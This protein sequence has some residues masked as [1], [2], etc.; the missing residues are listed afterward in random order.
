MFNLLSILQQLGHKVTFVPANLAYEQPYVGLLQERGI[1]VIHAPYAKSVESYIVKHARHFDVI[2]LSRANVADR[3]IGWINKYAPDAL[4]I[5][6]TVDLHF[7]REQR[8]AEVFQSAS[9]RRLA[10]KRKRQ[11][12]AI[13]SRADITLVVSPVEKSILEEMAP[14]LSVEIVSTIHETQGGATSFEQREGILFIGGFHHPPNVDAVVYYVQ[15]IVPLIRQ[16]L[17]EI[18]HYIVGSNPPLR[19]ISLAADDIEVTGYVKDVSGYFNNCRLSV[20]PL[21]YGSGV[22]GKVNMSMSYGLPVVAT[23]VAAEGVFLTHESDVLIGDDARSFA[24]AVVRLYS[25]E[26]LWKRLSENG[27]KNIE[28]HFSKSVARRALEDILSAHPKAA[29]FR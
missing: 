21:R 10:E 9:L 18:T 7:V 25:D 11:E 4:V 22:K 15:E 14:E 12:L 1:E 29:V 17:G 20:A 26:V 3:F 5:F 8:M 16:E 2:V 24:H 23:S 13:A 6:D 28:K 27:L 19:V